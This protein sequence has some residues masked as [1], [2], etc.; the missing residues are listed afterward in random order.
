MVKVSISCDKDNV[1]LCEVLLTLTLK[2]VK[3]V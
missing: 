3:V 2:A 1:L